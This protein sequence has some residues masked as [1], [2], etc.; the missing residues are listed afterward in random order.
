MVATITRAM[1]SKELWIQMEVECGRYHHQ[2]LTLLSWVE[3]VMKI[4]N[5]TKLAMYKDVRYDILKQ[6]LYL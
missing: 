1:P 4:E 3:R 2:N 6:S 5:D